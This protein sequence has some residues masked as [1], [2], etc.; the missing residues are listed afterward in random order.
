V[1]TENTIPYISQGD[2]NKIDEYAQKHLPMKKFQLPENI[3][4]AVAF[5]CSPKAAFI[6][7]VALDVDGAARWA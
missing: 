5:L 3:G 6:T 4:D 2:P 7:G 1:L